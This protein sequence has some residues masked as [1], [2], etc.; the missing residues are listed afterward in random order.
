MPLPAKLFLID[1]GNAT[2][3]ESTDTTIVENWRSTLQ[4]DSSFKLLKV[5]RDGP[6]D[7][8]RWPGCPGSQ[9]SPGLLE[10]R[11]RVY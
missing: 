9:R 5:P 11:C 8:V 7:P 6:N 3:G 10:A 1:Y 4:I 2:N